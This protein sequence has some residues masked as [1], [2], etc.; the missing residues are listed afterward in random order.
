M[1]LTNHA[2]YLTAANTP[3]S[4]RE[5]PYTPPGPTELLV[6]TSAVAI[7]AVDGYKQLLGDAFLP[8]IKIPCVPGN[9]LAGQVVEIGSHVTRFAPGDRIIAEAA[10][11]ADFGNRPP[12]GAFQEYVVVREHLTAKIPS[13]IPYDRASV[14]PLCFSH[15]SIWALSRQHART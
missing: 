2:A 15:C 7:N 14:L 12:E 3:L 6:R 11:T 9:D 1:A 10:G 5:A 13:H 8:N 4:V